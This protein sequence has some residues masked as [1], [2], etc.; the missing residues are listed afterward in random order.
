MKRKNSLVPY[1]LEE[2][3][4]PSVLASARRLVDQHKPSI[5][6]CTSRL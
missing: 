4:R 5:A 2:N 3:N 1:G 6:L